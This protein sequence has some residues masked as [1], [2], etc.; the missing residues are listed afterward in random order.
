VNRV[1]EEFVGASE[2]MLRGQLAGQA[3]HCANSLAHPKGCGFGPHCQQCIVRGTLLDTLE[4]GR[5]HHQ[6]EATLPFRSQGRTQDTTF[7]LSSALL[8]VRD[9]PRV[10]VA[11][12]DITKRKHA[13]EEVLRLNATLEQR[14]RE[15]TAQLEAANKELEAFAYSVSHDLRAPLRGIDGWSLALAED[16]AAGL[17]QRAHEYLR[18]VRSEAQRMGQL[19]D[20]LLELSRVTRAEMSFSSVDLTSV[21]RIIASR[22]REGSPGRAMEFVIQEGMKATGDERLLAVALGNLMGNAVKFTSRRSQARIEIGKTPQN[23]EPAFYVRDNGTGF[24]MA[25]AGALFAP[26]QRLHKTSE[27]PGTGI[28][29]ATV[30]RIVHRHGGRVWAQAR[31]DEGATF[32]FTMGMAE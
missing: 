15:R 16:Y 27:F 9:E 18:R 6:V 21:A 12:Q 3:L 2:A 23:G 10:L 26:F 17:D 20:D 19:I 11:I 29:L 22:L 32:Y 24:D 8:S 30:Q 31:L 5:S 7:L 28:G 1:A 4:S 13:E 25:Y 14:V